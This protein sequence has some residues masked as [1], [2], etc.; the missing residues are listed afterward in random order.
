MRDVIVGASMPHTV[1]SVLGR[2][3]HDMDSGSF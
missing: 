2:F 1:T 3:M